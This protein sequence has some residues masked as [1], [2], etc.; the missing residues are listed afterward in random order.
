MNDMLETELREAL[1]ARA[2][3]VPA[4][5]VRRV[6]GRDYRPRTRDLRPPVAGGALACAA[7][8]GGLA[9]A[10]GLSHP[11][12]AFAGWSA[13]PT[14]AKPD[15][16]SAAGSSCLAKLQAI[17]GSG[18]DRAVSAKSGK[19]LLPPLS[20]MS[21]VLS[22]IRGPF[23]FL[24]YANSDGSANAA[25]F[26]APGF[27]S[28][29]EMRAAGPVTPVAADGVSVV[30]QSQAMSQ[31]NGYTFIEGQAGSG[32]SQVTLNLTDGSTVQATTE[33]GWFAAWWPGSVGATT[34]TLTTSSGTTTATLPTPDLP[35]CPPSPPGDQQSTCASSS[36]SGSRGP[37]VGMQS[38]G[39]TTAGS[40]VPMS[41]GH[42]SLR[43]PAA[44]HHASRR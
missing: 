29:S 38:G 40:M 36:A 7:A 22:D 27:T 12:P 19:P 37:T 15:Q 4:S 44:S 10:L 43:T 18:A 8:A 5:A 20:S 1:T 21:Q 41:A 34:A 16:V 32:V 3:E 35:S 11:S 14:S 9:V 23:T 30:R 28:A 33:N 42:L 25:C 39:G 31:G 6:R 26:E 13:H 17:S 2:D 24:V